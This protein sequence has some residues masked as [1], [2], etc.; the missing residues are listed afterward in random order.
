MMR[1][2]N[3]IGL[4]DMQHGESGQWSPCSLRIFVFPKLAGTEKSPLEHNTSFNL[5]DLL[6]MVAEATSARAP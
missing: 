3:K 1:C 2:D 5:K 4:P 6:Q